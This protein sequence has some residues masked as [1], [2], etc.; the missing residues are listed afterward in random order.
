MINMRS[1]VDAI[2]PQDVWALRKTV[3]NVRNFLLTPTALLE[4]AS[5]IG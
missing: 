4:L 3:P 5:G 1:P 2:T